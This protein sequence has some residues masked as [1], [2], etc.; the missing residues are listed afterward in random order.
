MRNLKN[1]L[2]KFILIINLIIGGFYVFENKEIKATSINATV[3]I[4]STISNSHSWLMVK[5][6]GSSTIKI[7]HYSLSKNETVTIGTWGNIKQHTGIWYNYE[8][9]LGSNN[10]PN[11]VSISRT[12][13]S[14]SQL[15]AFNS[16]INKSDSWS[17]LNTCSYFAGYVW[18]Q[19]FSTKVNVGVFPKLLADSIKQVGNYTTNRSMPAKSNKNIYYHTSSGITQCTNPIGGGSSSGIKSNN[20]TSF[21]DNQLEQLEQM[22]IN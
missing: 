19:T 17:L 12:I 10:F 1:F 20:V 14:A 6:N 8:A 3:T 11:H 15:N 22:Y 2:V 5:N 21:P 4:F 18:C 16:A 9:Y 7:G 13:T